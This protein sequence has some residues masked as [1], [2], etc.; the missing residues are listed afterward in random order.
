MNETFGFREIKTKRDASIHFQAF[1]GLDGEA[2]FVQVEQFAQIHNHAGV[3]TIEAGIHRSV[4]FLTHTP[5]TLS[6]G[7]PCNW[8]R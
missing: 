3:Q 4:E 8:I 6:V 7:S 1:A 2:V 5:T